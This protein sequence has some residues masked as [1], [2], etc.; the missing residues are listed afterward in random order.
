MDILKIIKNQIEQ[1]SDGKELIGLNSVLTHIERAEFLLEQGIGNQDEA[2]FT[3][4]IYRTNQ[5]FEGMLKEAY[6]FLS[7][8]KNTSQLTPFKIEKYL[9]DNDIF[10]ERVLEQFSNYRQKWRNPS[11]HD[12]KLFFGHSES[13]LAIIS[14]SAFI[15]L[16]LNQIIE[17]SAFKIE[18]KKL[19]ESKKDIKGEI[20]GYSEKD[21]LLKLSGIL[22][23]F[24]SETPEIEFV[25]NEY[26]L[27]G[28]IEAYIRAADND[29]E[30]FTEPRLSAGER[31]NLR[32]DFIIK[33]KN[34]KIVIEVKRTENRASITNGINQL[35]TY[36]TVGN[37]NKGILFIPPKINKHLVNIETK[38]I[39]VDDKEL[40]IVLITPG[41]ENAR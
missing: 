4:V 19:K 1:I 22:L 27:I 25:K 2:F 29:F 26:E 12:H 15:H 28:M 17:K 11:T 41:N 7:E 38:D 24:A 5:A 8:K 30:I 39:K 34:E 6:L 40:N 14:V 20:V 36:L 23:K 16:L 13:F 3:D 18:T 35:T 31:I 9:T 21:D 33:T 32:P 37:M 10:K